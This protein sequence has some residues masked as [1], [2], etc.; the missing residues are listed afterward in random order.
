[1]RE[2]GDLILK[3][4]SRQGNGLQHP[5]AKCARKSAD[6]EAKHVMPQFDNRS[7]GFQKE[8][9]LELLVLVVVVSCFW[10]ASELLQL[11]APVALRR[12]RAGFT[13][14]WERADFLQASEPC[15]L[16]FGELARMGLHLLDCLGEICLAARIAI[17]SR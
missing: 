15:C 8:H 5:P 11:V 6:R 9:F 2:N 1:M 3:A 14:H 17:T 16:S 12:P 4:A 13:R 10:S 7:S